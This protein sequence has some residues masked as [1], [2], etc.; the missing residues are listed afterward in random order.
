MATF[1]IRYETDRVLVDVEVPLLPHL[2]TQAR[3]AREVVRERQVREKLEAEGVEVYEC[4]ASHVLSNLRGPGASGTFIYSRTA[5]KAPKKRRTPLK[6]G[7]KVEKVIKDLT[8]PVEPAIIEEQPTKK[9][10]RVKRV[11][12]T[13]NQTTS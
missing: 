5:P 13:G 1:N 4:L 10:K 6:T 11:S 3:D 2:A 8:P 12:K 7:P 9:R